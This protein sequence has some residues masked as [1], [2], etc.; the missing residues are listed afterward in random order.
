MIEFWVDTV[1]G[2]WGNVESIAIVEL[3][4]EFLDEFANMSN[5]ERSRF[6][7]EHGTPAR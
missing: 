3:E 7:K 5:W 1:D 4:E 6:A 2:M